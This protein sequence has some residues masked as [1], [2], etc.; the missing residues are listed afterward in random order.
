ML[1]LLLLLAA[2]VLGL[3]VGRVVIKPGTDIDLWMKR[4][5]LRVTTKFTKD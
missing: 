5:W 4:M 3:F 1:N 2:F